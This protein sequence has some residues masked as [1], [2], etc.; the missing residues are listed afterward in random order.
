MNILQAIDWHILPAL[1]TDISTCNYLNVLIW[2]LTESNVNTVKNCL[3]AH[4]HT[5]LAS[6]IDPFPLSFKPP[7]SKKERRNGSI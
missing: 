3:H 4:F 2:S 6:Y 5:S 7:H 1:L